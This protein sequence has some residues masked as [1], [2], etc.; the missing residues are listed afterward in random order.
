MDSLQEFIEIQLPYNI[1]QVTETNL[2]DSNFLFISLHDAL[3]HILSDLKNIKELLKQMTNYIRNKSINYNKSN[4]IPDLKRIGKV[5]WNFILAIYDSKWDSLVSNDNNRL[6]RQKITYQ[7][8][9]KI[10]EIKNKRKIKKSTD[11]LASFNNIPSPIP[12]KIQKEVNKIS[13]YFK[14][15]YLTKRKKRTIARNYMF[16]RWLHP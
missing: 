3:E 7:F 12:A 14:K 4:N 2:W 11:K 16:R 8:T 5:V 15:K 13:K 1:N 10:P 6:L 9:P